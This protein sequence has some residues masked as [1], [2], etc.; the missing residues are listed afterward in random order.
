MVGSSKV[1]V[2]HSGARTWGQR[3]ADDISE[4]THDDDATVICHSDA[5]NGR[6]LTEN[7]IMV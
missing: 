3:E 7:A 6:K 1:V 5:V 4:G 2:G